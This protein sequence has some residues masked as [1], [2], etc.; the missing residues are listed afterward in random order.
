MARLVVEK[1]HIIENYRLL[2][3]HAGVPV[4]PVLKANGYG[5]GAEG[6]FELLKEEGV[7]LMAVS[8]LEEALPLSGR[9]VEILVLSCGRSE[10]YAK[11][12][13]EAGVTAAV[14]SLDFAKTLSALAEEAGKT[15]RVHIKVDTGMGRFGF[16]PWETKEMA[17]V[18]S[19]PGLE[20][21]GIFTHC[22][23]A[24]LENGSMEEQ[25]AL[26]EETL[27]ALEAKGIQLPMCHMA[28]SSAA[29]KS[30]E[31]AMDAVR[32]GSALTGRVPM[33]THLPLQKAGRFE[34]EILAIRTL[35]AGSN[36]GYGS[37]CKLKKDTK[38]A[39]V[40]AGTADGLLRGKEPDLFRF[41]DI[42]RYLYHDLLLFFKKPHYC[43]RVN[44][45]AAPMLGRPATNHSF[46][47]VT[48]VP[49]QEGDFM[50]LNVAPLRVDATVERIYE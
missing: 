42:C 14:D 40:A 49:C 36:L 28:N 38:V 50:V 10:G 8:R 7:S 29:L 35:P 22:H 13:L 48:D 11:A 17:E 16:Q 43:G 27:S 33:K 5:L 47:D 41:M 9:E 30:K 25:K 20:V 37:V 31:F 12:L 4:I 34:A 23:S 45:K 3:E 44:G 18:F 46:F 26:F 39:V 32:I 2:Q 15:V 19:L 21:T 6:L 1:S 24:F